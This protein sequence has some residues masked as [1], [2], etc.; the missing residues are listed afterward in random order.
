MKQDRSDQ[1]SDSIESAIVTFGDTRE[2][3]TLKMKEGSSQHFLPHFDVGNDTI[4]LRLDWSDTDKNNHP[5]LDADFLD[6]ATLKHRALRGE[7]KGAHHTASSSGEGRCYNWEFR[8]FSRQFNVAITWRATVSE[9]A[10]ATSSCS[11]EI[12]RASD[13]KS[14]HGKFSANE[15]Q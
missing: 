7:R 11:A 14:E 5:M 10:H 2:V 13:R 6:P 9:N 15:V 8:G 3:F 12:I 1:P 4:Q